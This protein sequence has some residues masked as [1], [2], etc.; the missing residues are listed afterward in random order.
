MKN[1]KISASN[2]PPA[3][4]Q[5]PMKSSG[6]SKYHP[7]KTYGKIPD[8]ITIIIG[9]TNAHA[10]PKNANMIH[11]T[12]GQPI[13]ETRSSIPKKAIAAMLSMKNTKSN[14]GPYRPN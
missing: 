5:N 8:E 12:L 6:N 1:P 3:A 7:P 13:I 14:G 11:R 4:S 10:K 9:A 2:A